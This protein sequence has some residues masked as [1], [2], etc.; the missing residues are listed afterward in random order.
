MVEE[1]AFLASRQNSDRNSSSLLH[2]QHQVTNHPNGHSLEDF[3][4]SNYKDAKI[5]QI[6]QLRTNNADSGYLR[7]LPQE[8]FSHVLKYVEADIV[9][10]TPGYPPYLMSWYGGAMLASLP[11]FKKKMLIPKKVNH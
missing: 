9:K 1:L 3:V 2:I 10:N 5:K 8:L 11:I 7:T 6:Q 4:L